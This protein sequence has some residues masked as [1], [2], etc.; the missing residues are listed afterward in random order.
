VGLCRVS[1]TIVGEDED[2]KWIDFVETGWVADPANKF[3]A[4]AAKYQP[5]SQPG[6]LCESR[7]LGI[8]TEVDRM[9]RLRARRTRK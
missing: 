9:G 5:I 7:G 2:W 1:K 8:K 6:D 3:Q 4:L